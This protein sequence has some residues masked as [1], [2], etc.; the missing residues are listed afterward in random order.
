M[1]YFF[2][3]AFNLNEGEISDSAVPHSFGGM[4]YIAA[5]EVANLS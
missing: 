4:E 1:L 5:A 3:N 2:L